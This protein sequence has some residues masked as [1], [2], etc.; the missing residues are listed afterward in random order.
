MLRAQDRPQ[1]VLA[2]CDNPDIVGSDLLLAKLYENHP[3]CVAPKRLQVVEIVEPEPAAV[4]VPVINQ[5][6][7]QLAQVI[8]I[9]VSDVPFVPAQPSLNLIIREVAEF[10][11]LSLLE[12]ISDRRNLEI[13]RPRQTAMYLAKKLTTKSYPFIGRYLGGRDHTTVLHATRKIEELMGSSP[14]L[15]DEVDVLKLRIATA[16]L[17]PVAA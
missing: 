9:P 10:Y 2:P 6:P 4:V 17:N 11:G 15:V 16:M 7:P 12:I 8:P 1:N 13:V 3:E 5:G 14:R